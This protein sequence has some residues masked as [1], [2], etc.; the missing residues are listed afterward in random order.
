MYNNLE[1][2]KDKH[3][4]GSLKE[5]TEYFKDIF[6]NDA[7]FRYRTLSCHGFDCTLMFMDG[8]INAD[9]LSESIVRPL[10]LA[11]PEKGEKI[12]DFVQKKVVFVG[13]LKRT[14]EVLEILR[15]LL[16]GDTVI[17]LEEGDAM[18]INTKGWRTRGI[19]E[20]NDERI[21]QGPREGFDEAAMLNIA[22][23]RRKLPTPD[24][25][26]EMQHLGKRTDTKV[27]ICYLASLIKK[28]VLKE[29]KKRLSK[30]NIDGVLDSNYINE[31]IKD[32]RYSILKTVGTT[33][34]PDIV[35]AR[36]L[37]GRVAVI[38]DGT[39]VVLTLPYLFC[40]NFQSDDDY[41]LNFWV[42]SVG[43]MLRYICFFL[44]T[45]VPAIYLSLVNFFPSLLPTT[46]VISISAARSGIPFPAF[47][48]CI[49]LIF[50][51]EVL[52][53]TGVRMPQSL[54]HALSI[55]GGLVVGQA[56]V[57]AKIVSA[58]MLIVVALSGICGLMIPRLKGVVFY[59]RIIFT[60]MSSLFGLLGFFTGI[61]ALLVLT[62][63][64]DS[65]GADYSESAK[66]FNMSS[67]KDVYWRVPWWQMRTRP[68]TLSDNQIR[69][70][71]GEK[72]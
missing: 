34:R 58:P 26:V 45:S 21:L 10:L 59:A 50:V 68:M 5:K 66:R 37:E 49:I 55:V 67:L 11:S 63:K 72:E 19:S 4:S 24:L 46:F 69:N 18:V 2:F 33:E 31:L 53:E 16:Y 36:L 23:L 32:N 7:V 1:D 17:L 42:A 39:P 57:E 30:I 70:R 71:S 54:G 25:Q 6:K 12:D 8:L 41:Y 65:F 20:P 9:T 38:V 13:E 64:M 28:D 48:E 61:S 47:V 27:F 56:A 60:L 35:A 29:L 22:M 15:G 62:L 40:E 52:K 43:R 44:A 51:F 14:T 3:I